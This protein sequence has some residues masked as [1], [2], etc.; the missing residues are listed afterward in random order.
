M[1]LQRPKS[2]YL[3]RLVAAILALFLV[4]SLSTVSY[5]QHFGKLMVNPGMTASRKRHETIF[6]EPTIDEKA[7]ETSHE[8][9][10]SVISSGPHALED[11]KVETGEKFLQSLFNVKTGR[12]GPSTL[13]EKGIDLFA[14]HRPDRP[15]L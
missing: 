14:N 3:T 1:K 12:D 6:I 5:S 13:T 9:T 2:K 4:G 11:G 8:K 15:E 7:P 10:R